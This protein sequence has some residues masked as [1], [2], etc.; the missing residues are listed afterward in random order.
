[1]PTTSCT[2]VK[3]LSKH[4]SRQ[5][6]LEKHEKEHAERS[7]HSFKECELAVE[8]KNYYIH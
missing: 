3:K 6:D 2:P 4:C 1:M 5:K 7:L 8:G